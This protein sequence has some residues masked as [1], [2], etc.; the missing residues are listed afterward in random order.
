MIALLAKKEPRYNNRKE[1]MTSMFG[2][3]LKRFRKDP[4]TSQPILSFHMNSALVLEKK[5]FSDKNQSIHRKSDRIRSFQNPRNFIRHRG[6]FL[7]T[8]PFLHQDGNDNDQR[9]KFQGGIWFGYQLASV[10]KLR[11]VSDGNLS[12]RLVPGVHVSS[13]VYDWFVQGKRMKDH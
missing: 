1:G 12:R 13:S 8:F 3:P 5:R 7:K 9:P 11:L 4:A 2:E 10:G 6:F